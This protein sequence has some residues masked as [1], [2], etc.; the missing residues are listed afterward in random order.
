ML[1][2]LY[3]TFIL[4]VKSLNS[5]VKNVRDKQSLDYGYKFTF[6][7]QWIV[8]KGNVYAIVE[9]FTKHLPKHWNTFVFLPKHIYLTVV[10]YE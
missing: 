6:N 5:E 10:M 3:K 8:G 4:V 9:F 7:T 2:F 1:N